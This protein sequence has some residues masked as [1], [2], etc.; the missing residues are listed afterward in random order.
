MVENLTTCLAPRCRTRSRILGVQPIF[1]R[2]APHSWEDGLVD[3][4]GRRCRCRWCRLCEPRRL[5]AASFGGLVEKVLFA[6]VANRWPVLET[7]L[8]QAPTRSVLFM[9]RSPQGRTQPHP[10]TPSTTTRTAREWQDSS[11][12]PIMGSL[13]RSL[14]PHDVVVWVSSS[15]QGSVRRR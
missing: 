12:A 1:T 13:P 15:A 4:S 6:W 2:F 11:V 5:V 8:T 3:R 10:P 14:W 7:A 9:E